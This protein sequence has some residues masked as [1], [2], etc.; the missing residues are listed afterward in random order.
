[1]E[2]IYPN[3]ASKIMM[4]VDLQGNPG[5][6]IFEAAHRNPGTTIFWHLDKE[7]LGSTITFHQMALFPEPGQHTITIID[8]DG[9]SLTRHFEIVAK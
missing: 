4:P 1:M 7:Y 5:K 6:T 2:L 9:E 3:K 8:E